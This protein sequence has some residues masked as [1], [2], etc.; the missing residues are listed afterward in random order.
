MNYKKRKG[1]DIKSMEFYNFTYLENQK[2][3]TDKFFLLE[4]NSLV[5]LD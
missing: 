3:V 2:F 4:I 1:G 5:C